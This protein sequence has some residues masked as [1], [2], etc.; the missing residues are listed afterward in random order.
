VVA[1]RVAI[2]SG[3]HDVERFVNTTRPKRHGGKQRLGRTLYKTKKPGAV[4]QKIEEC[5][6][7]L[8]EMAKFENTDAEKFAF[9]VSAFLA[10]FRSVDYKVTGITEEVSGLQGKIN[11]RQAARAD[12][13]VVFLLEP[14]KKF[15]G[16]RPS[17]YELFS[18][19]PTPQLISAGV[20]LSRVSS[21]GVAGQGVLQRKLLTVGSFGSARE[22]WS[23]WL[24]RRSIHLKNWRRSN[25]A[26]LCCH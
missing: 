10:A 9:V 11:W 25:C 15:M 13:A 21:A 14:I 12:A 16:T 20:V 7:F 24:R 22:I 18:T 6:Y 5:H 23:R 4:L 19:C 1:G 26:R 8:A 17:S 3:L 2:I